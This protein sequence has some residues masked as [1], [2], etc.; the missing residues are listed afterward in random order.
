MYIGD[1]ALAGNNISEIENI[2]QLLDITFK[3]K[4]PGDLKYFLGLEVAR[5]NYGIH[6]SQRRYTLDI[7]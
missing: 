2:T 5:N 3:I 7:I 4:D 1:V 6:I